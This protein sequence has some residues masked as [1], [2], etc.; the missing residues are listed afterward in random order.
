MLLGSSWGR[1]GGSENLSG[2]LGWHFGRLEASVALFI[3]GL[4][5]AR[6]GLLS[7]SSEPPSPT[8]FLDL[9]GQS[10]TQHGRV[11]QVA[12]HETSRSRTTGHV[13]SP[14]RSAHHRSQVATCRGPLG[15]P[16]AVVER[17][18]CIGDSHEGFGGSLGSLLEASRAPLG[19]AWAPLG[20]LLERA[21][22]L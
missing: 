20:A 16:R 12:C 4:L 21:W 22:E 6:R 14:G 3:W 10:A 19:A 1:C 11:P 15:G 13:S 17:L 18:G 2:C 8:S 7:A 5:G 9:D